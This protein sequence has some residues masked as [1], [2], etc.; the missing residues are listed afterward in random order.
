MSAVNPYLG[1]KQRERWGVIVVDGKTQFPGHVISLS[2]IE[3]PI[4]WVTQYSLGTTGAGKIFKGRKLV[5]GCKIACSL[6][7]K[8]AYDAAVTFYKT[9]VKT[10]KGV[11]GKAHTIDHPA[12]ASIEMTKF[13]FTKEPATMPLTNG[14]WIVTYTI[15]EY[16]KVEVA[17][18]G[19]ADPA[20][21]DD[22]PKPKDQ[23]DKALDAALKV[24][25]SALGEKS[26]AEVTP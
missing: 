3:R 4:E 9:Y 1:P 12:F 19:P 6:P 22:P 18:L 8:D 13:V 11:R 24:M 5:E 7:N 23:L 15:D 14:S 26:V 10:P 25:N 2:D 20:K 21:L 16:E 17:P